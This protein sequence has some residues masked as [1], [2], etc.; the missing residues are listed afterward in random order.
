MT[1]ALIFDLDNTLYPESAYFQAIFSQLSQQFNL[2]PERFAFLFKDFD[3]IRFSQRDIFGFALE[4][5]ACFSK[6]YHEALFQLFTQIDTHL[7]P[8]DGVQACIDQAIEAG[9]AIG[10]L[11]NGQVLAQTQ[12]WNC[13]QLDR[14]ANIH[15]SAARSL[16][17]DKPAS[18]T[19]EAFL[20]GMGFQP[21]DCLFI[22]DRYANDLDWGI[23]QGGKGILIHSHEEVAGVPQV[24]DFFELMKEI[25]RL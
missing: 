11:T 6:E 13:L 14:K 24:R 4:Q 3:R 22:G 21:Q 5:A 15:F 16:G 18:S 8:Y 2:E 17:A 7:I 1:K 9:L 23:Q 10:V 19:Y 12:K 20:N 25:E